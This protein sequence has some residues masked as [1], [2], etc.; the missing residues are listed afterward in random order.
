VRENDLAVLEEYVRRTNKKVFRIEPSQDL[1]PEHATGL[2][3]I[4]AT[5]TV[6]MGMGRNKANA[7]VPGR[8]LRPF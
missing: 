2:N 3:F 8:P 1:D 7:T 6:W 5:M 4:P